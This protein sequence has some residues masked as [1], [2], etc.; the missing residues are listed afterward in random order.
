LRKGYFTV[1][2]LHQKLLGNQIEDVRDKLRNAGDVGVDKAEGNRFGVDVRI[3]LNYKINSERKCVNCL[4]FDQNT[5]QWPAAVSSAV[6]PQFKLVGKIS[7]M[8][9][10]E[11]QLPG[12][13]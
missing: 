9:L 12:I 2:I 10:Y 4:H 6:N 1:C 3:P 13:S 5:N 11:Q 7:C 8:G